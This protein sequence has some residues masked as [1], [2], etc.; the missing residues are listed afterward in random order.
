MGRITV[1]YHPGVGCGGSV[2][3]SVFIST[4]DGN[5]TYGPFFAGGF[6]PGTYSADATYASADTTI[7]TDANSTNCVAIT[8]NEANPTMS[9]LTYAPDPAFAGNEITFSTTLSSGSSPTGGAGDLF[10]VAYTD[11][12]CNTPAFTLSSNQTVD[13]QGNGAYTFTTTSP[14]AAGTY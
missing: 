11:S 12:S 14:P 9:P 2:L 3:A 10:M 4:I 5:G 13:S 7:N 6:L 8:F 1:S